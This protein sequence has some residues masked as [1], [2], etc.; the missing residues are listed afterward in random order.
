M[1]P[2]DSHQ[3]VLYVDLFQNIPDTEQ[4]GLPCWFTEV[5]KIPDGRIVDAEVLTA[6]ADTH[7]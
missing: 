6:T 2:P 4:C 7:T 1:P 5:D 3:V